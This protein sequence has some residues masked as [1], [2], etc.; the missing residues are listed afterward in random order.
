MVGKVLLGPELISKFHAMGLSLSQAVEASTFTPAKVLG[1]D[2]EIGSLGIGMRGDAA[3]FDL[4]SGSYS[5]VDGLGNNSVVNG[6]T[7]LVPAMT[8]SSGAIAWSK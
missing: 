3:V 7:L 1:K 6:D 2:A 8:L 5:F 4:E